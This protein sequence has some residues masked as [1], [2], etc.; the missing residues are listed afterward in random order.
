MTRTRSMLGVTLAIALLLTGQGAFVT[1]RAQAARPAASGSTL[2]IV[3]AHDAVGLDPQAVEDNSAGFVMATI[4]DQLLEYR[5]GTVTVGPGLATSYT[6][7]NGGKTYTFTLRKGVRF[8]DGTPFNATALVQ[9]LDRLLNPRNKYYVLKE[10]GVES[11]IRFTYGLVTSYTAVNKDTVRITLS[12]PF[13]PF[14]ASLAMVWSGV[15]SPAAVRKYG[16]LGVLQHPVG[17][18]PYRFVEWVKNDHITVEANPYYWGPKPHIQRIIFQ[19]VP[20]GSVRLLKLQR[21]E[22]QIDADVTTRDYQA[23]LHTRGIKVLSQ[24]G[25]A[26]NGIGMTV[27]VKPL[28][29]KRVRQALNY[30]VD[31]RALAKFLFKGLGTPMN[32]Y[33]PP[34]VSGYDASL[35]GYPYNPTKARQLLAAAGYPRGFTITLLAYTNPRGYNPA[36]GD[37]AVAVQQYLK[38]IGVKANIKIMDFVAFLHKVRSGTYHGLFMTGWSGDNGDPDDFLYVLFSSDQIPVGNNAHLRDTHLDSLL[39]QARETSDPAQRT[40]LYR[41]AQRILNDDAPWIMGTYTSLVRL[42]TSNVHG[43][44]LNP[45][46]MFFY[47]NR[48]SLS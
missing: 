12:R 27:D 47:M 10:P 32:S 24:V 42:T 26:I 33:L 41:Q 19:I 29:D 45:T 39:R 6:V 11:F 2:T 9:D 40:R 28:N 4:F 31:R 44:L 48:V 8:Q 30:A 36:G 21:G 38:A 35:P 34:S 46:Q 20:E 5:P 13:A 14:P 1:G 15:M 16:A 23:A 3:M 37:L 7:S 25:Q 43:Y 22:A 18:G 17:T